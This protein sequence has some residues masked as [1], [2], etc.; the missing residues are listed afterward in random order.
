MQWDDG[1]NQYLACKEALYWNG[2]TV[3]FLAA[4]YWVNFGAHLVFKGFLNDDQVQ[5][6]SNLASYMLG[7][8]IY[9]IQTSLII[10]SIHAGSLRCDGVY[11]FN[12]MWAHTR[13]INGI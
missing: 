10:L 13:K 2:V 8:T 11:L 7:W 6:G 3:T 5:S 4:I 1:Q 9:S 12:Q